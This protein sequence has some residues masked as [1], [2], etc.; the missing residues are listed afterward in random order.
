MANVRQLD[1]VL[2][3]ISLNPVFSNNCFIDGHEK[4]LMCTGKVK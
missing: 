4:I 1:M 2:N 3:S